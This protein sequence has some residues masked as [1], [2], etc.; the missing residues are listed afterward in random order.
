C[1]IIEAASGGCR[2]PDLELRHSMPSAGIQFAKSCVVVQPTAAIVSDRTCFGGAHET[3]HETEVPD[4]CGR[5]DRSFEQRRLRPTGR[6]TRQGD[7][8]HLLRSEGAG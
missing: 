7:F 2:I 1:N 3:G 4:T 8:S 5:T 6:E